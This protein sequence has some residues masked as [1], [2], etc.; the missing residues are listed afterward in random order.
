[1]AD[2]LEDVLGNTEWKQ[3]NPGGDGGGD[4]VDLNIGESLVG[5]FNGSSEHPSKFNPEKPSVLLKLTRPDGSKAVLWAKG[6]LGYQMAEVKPGQL[7]KI[8][9]LPD[10]TT[11]KGFTVKT[12][13]VFTAA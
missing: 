5:T 6:N 11:K 2:S 9:R 13:V 1:M 8:E 3:V 4:A 10:E 7:V 12:F